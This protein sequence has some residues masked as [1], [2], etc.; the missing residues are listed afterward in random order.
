MNNIALCPQ[1][2][3]EGKDKYMLYVDRY[4][5]FGFCSVKCQCDYLLND[6]DNYTNQILCNAIEYK[7]SGSEYYTNLF[8]NQKNIIDSL[9]Q[10]TNKE[11]VWKSIYLR[12][13]LL[14]DIAN[15]IIQY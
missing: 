8:N 1:C 11:N 6:D 2:H 14:K 5:N 13:H 3:I 4:V 12:K 10:Q 15:I 9:S 7:D